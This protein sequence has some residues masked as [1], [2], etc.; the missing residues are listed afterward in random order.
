MMFGFPL[1]ELILASRIEIFLFYVKIIFRQTI[2]YKSVYLKFN[3]NKI[4]YI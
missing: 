2:K 4:N 3:S 1:S